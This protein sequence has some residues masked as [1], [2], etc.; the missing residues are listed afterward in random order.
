MGWPCSSGKLFTK[1]WLREGGDS[2][3]TRPPNAPL[4]TTG[5][6]ADIRT[7]NLPNTRQDCWPVSQDVRWERGFRTV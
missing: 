7:R 4:V 6:H 1:C 5:V 3:Q 2:D